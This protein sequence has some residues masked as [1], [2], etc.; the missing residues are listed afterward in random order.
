MRKLILYA[1]IALVLSFYAVS[2]IEAGSSGFNV[3][4]DSTDPCAGGAA[5]STY[6]FTA[7]SGS[8]K[9]ITMARRET[10]EYDEYSSTDWYYYDQDP[11]A[12]RLL[13]RQK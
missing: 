12:G 8:N 10:K 2:N 7:K 1:G 11:G 3:S 13:Y 4:I 5:D 6:I 9:Q